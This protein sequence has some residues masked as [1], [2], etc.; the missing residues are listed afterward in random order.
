MPYRLL[1]ALLLCCTTVHAGLWP[2]KIIAYRG[3]TPTLDGILA[4]GE[5]DDAVQL[6]DFSTWTSQFSAVQREADLDAT[7]WIKHDGHSLYFAFDVRD[8]IVYGW[9]TQ[10]WLPDE[11]PQAH[12]LSRQ[13]WPWFGDGVEILLNPPYKWFTF[14]NQIA[15]GD[16]S[17]WQMV[18]STY[19]SRLGGVGTGGLLEGEPRNRDHAWENYTPWIL[20][21]AM[22][23]AVRIKDKAAEG[24]G[25]IIEWKI[26]PE[27]CLEVAP[28]TY[29]S[30]DLGPW[31]MGLNLAIN[32]LDE[33]AQGSGNF[34]NF[35]HEQWWTGQPDQR[36]WLKQWGKL[37][38][39]PGGKPDAPEAYPLGTIR[40]APN[41]E[42]DLVPTTLQV[43]EKFRGQVN[44][45]LVVHLPPG[46]SAQVFAAPGLRGPRFMAWSPEGVLHVAN[47]KAGGAGQFTPPNDDDIVPPAEEMTGQIVALPDADADGVADTALVVVDKLWWANNLQFYQGDLYVGD[48]HAVR[49][50][51]DLDGDG[52]YETERPP[53]ALLPPAKNHRTRTIVFD[54]RNDKLYVSVGSTCDL[55]WEADPERATILQFNA[56]GSGR[57]IFSTGW[58]NA[59]G[60]ALHPKTN[61]LWATD[62]G[63]DLEG[64]ML[65]PEMID[66]V[67]NNGFYG[68]PLAYGFGAWTSTLVSSYNNT[69]TPFS[70]ADTLAVASMQRPA[71]L[72]P[73]HTAPMAIHFYTGDHL[74]IPFQDVAFVAL[75]GRGRAGN[76][77]GYKVV[78]LSGEP[79][80]GQMV[81]TDFLGSMLRNPDDIGSVWGKPVGLAADSLGHLY[82]SSDW[83]NHLILR[84]GADR[85]SGRWL[86][87]PVDRALAGHP[88]PLAGLVRLSFQASDGPVQVEAD[89]SPL[90][91]PPALPLVA[92][93]DSTYQLDYPL[94]TAPLG[95]YTIRLTLSQGRHHSTLVHSLKI[96]PDGDLVIF[97]DGD[98]NGW[99]AAPIRP[100]EVDLAA[101]GQVVQG[102]TA[103]ALSSNFRSITFAPPPGIELQGFTDLAFS[104]HPGQARIP[105][106][107]GQLRVSAD[108]DVNGL[109]GRS[110]Q[111]LKGGIHG[112]D[113]HTIAGIKVDL[114]DRQWQEVIVPLEQIQRTDQIKWIIFIGYL[115]GGPFYIDNIRLVAPA[116]GQS[117]LEP[118][119]PLEPVQL[120][121][122]TRLVDTHI[123]LYD[124]SRPEGVP[125]PGSNSE[126]YRPV[127]PSHFGAVA[128]PAG[129]TGAV[130]V[131]ASPWL[132]DN[133]WLL[134]LTQDDP[135]YRGIVG[136]LALDDPNFAGELARLAADGRFVGLRAKGLRAAAIEGPVI[137]ALHLLAQSGLVLDILLA[138]MDL[139]D[140]LALAQAVPEL[141]LVLN[142]AAGAR[143]DGSTPA[144]SW[145]QAVRA[146]AAQPQVYCKI[147]GLFQQSR[148]TPAPLDPDYYQPV[149]DILWEAFGPRR[150]VYGSNWPVSDLRGDYAAH[151]DL[152][153]AYISPKGQAAVEQVM[154]QNAVELYH[155]DGR[156]TAVTDGSISYPDQ[157][158]LAQNFPNPFNSGTQIGIVVPS[159]GAIDLGLYNLAGQRVATLVQENVAAGF[160]TISWNGRNDQGQPLASGVYLYR[161]ETVTGWIQTRKLVLL[162]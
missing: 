11:N 104:F 89:L 158:E 17:S 77:S 60:L 81:S 43:P 129:V 83:I 148:R 85:L 115:E 28:G 8:E 91:G 25:Y 134:D 102:E 21:G 37:V 119:E 117:P 122:P 13:S 62:N 79:E 121:Q 99:T 27:P 1:L 33:K 54:E 110:V 95:V 48:R 161:L 88:L 130:V 139:D 103:I 30:P 136:N 42:Q 138:N 112:V 101:T 97:D 155:L 133:Q 31:E 6:D 84:I 15:W 69:L 71:A 96:A 150:L 131:E 18:A 24:S 156:N 46:L 58:R 23:T 12:D 68:W 116:Q 57:R 65:P 47:M 40:L 118:V 59:V 137:E 114:D 80:G 51:S 135:T 45:D 82:V 160:H 5:Y 78:A 132:A 70:Q 34:A 63:H 49:R 94:A 145:T 140:A 157:P 106:V 41:I 4:P 14:D 19:K 108:S 100:E 67:R 26:G 29:W 50:F 74:P 128:R 10:A 76:T 73:A 141:P 75:R 55:C 113:S 159:A 126:L 72:L 149:L 9:D 144:E 35:H 92:L 98:A 66:I 107:A 86:R 32:D 124:P 44:E 154:W 22:E 2:K 20:T 52:I 152:V 142:H 87:P 146:L 39:M 90:G 120:L 162:R 127:L 53:L 125:W 93:D 153:L 105:E 56:D 123:H 147:S 143:I 3:S 109:S 7:V 16:G 36:T 64:E 38:L 61:Q 111:L 151:R